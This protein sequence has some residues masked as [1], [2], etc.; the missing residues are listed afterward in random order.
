MTEKDEVGAK[1]A[2]ALLSSL[3]DLRT[4]LE[5]NKRKMIQDRPKVNEKEMLDVLDTIE[6]AA[7]AEGAISNSDAE[8]VQAIRAAIEERDRLKK[9]IKVKDKLLWAHRLGDR[10]LADK[11]LNELEDIRDL[12]EVKP[13]PPEKGK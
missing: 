7:D 4:A 9:I 2:R 3:K 10:R 6:G 11:A 12:G 5:R 1:A 13:A 8:I